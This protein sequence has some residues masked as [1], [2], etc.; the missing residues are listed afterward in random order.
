MEAVKEYR[1]FT[2]YQEKEPISRLDQFIS[3]STNYVNESDVLIHKSKDFDSYENIVTLGLD[4]QN[5]RHIFVIELDREGNQF[6]VSPENEVIMKTATLT[7]L[8]HGLKDIELYLSK[9]LSSLD[10]KNE[11]FF[12]K[13]IESNDNK[14]DG[15][16]STVCDIECDADD[17]G[18]ESP[19][20]Y[21]PLNHF[22]KKH[23]LSEE[24]K[25][26]K[27]YATAQK[28]YKKKG[29]KPQ[30]IAQCL[31]EPF[32]PENIIS[33]VM[34]EEKDLKK[35]GFL[36]VEPVDYN[37]FNIDIV[38]TEFS[39]QDLKSQIAGNG[40]DG[41]CMNIK[42]NK[43]L[44]PFF[45]PQISFKY[46]RLKGNLAN[47]IMNLSFFNI[48][49]WNPTNSLST[50]VLGVYKILNKHAVIEEDDQEKKFQEITT[51]MDI[52]VKN[53]H[54]KVDS[55]PYDI[56]DI[57][58]HRL[59]I[60]SS[61]KPG[62]Q[63]FW[64]KGVGYGHGDKKSDW[65][66]DDLIKVKQLKTRMNITGLRNL[67]DILS[68]F[69]VDDDIYE[70][71]NKTPILKII[72][73]FSKQVNI[74]EI[75]TNYGLYH[76]LV[77]IFK[78]LDFERFSNIDEVAAI[79]KSLQ[80]VASQLQIYNKLQKQSEYYQMFFK[81]IVLSRELKNYLSESGEN[82]NDGDESAYCNKIKKLQVSD[83]D[84]KENFHYADLASTSKPSNVCLKRLKK[85]IST[86]TN[87]LPISYDTSVVMRYDE[88]N[89]QCLK[90]MIFGG[91]DTPYDSGCFEFD[92][93]IPESY[94][95]KPPQVNF[96]TTGKCTARLNPNLYKKGKVCL[97]LLGTWDGNE[98][99]KW[100]LRE[101]TLLQLFVSLQSFIF[102]EKPYFNEPTYES[103]IGTPEGEKKSQEYNNHT[104][105]YTLVWG[106]YNQLVNPSTCFK[107]VIET[108]FRAKRNYII[109]TL[110][111][112]EAECLYIVH[113]S[114]NIKQEFTEYKEKFIKL[115]NRL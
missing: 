67:K 104:R 61:K 64:G 6:T 49:T 59:P 43:D 17:E 5:Y 23:E 93:F 14:S 113:E 45:P 94:P 22:N 62:Q 80:D 72:N 56:G 10:R 82:V 96:L 33:R 7:K 91:K 102:C 85:E 71:L 36:T 109:E 92:I 3:W 111:K 38:Y 70:Y 88:R 30:G 2:V 47:A 27:I 79:A 68:V 4:F 41:I 16:A 65:S 39:K 18:Y 52:L 63:N 1:N 112:W 98:S 103:K 32:T 86:Y 73:Y 114:I 97:T 9:F 76:E 26:K 105:F 13:K 95:A 55:C 81:L 84:S 69:I 74:V 89:I 77:E 75:Q 8:K 20:S 115:L 35:K 108:H 60:S 46:P 53:N 54:L 66:I 87:S 78:M 58:H 50:L 57:D 90:L 51:V 37:P 21:D 40:H 15:S 101:S 44:Y 107:E 99:E 42:I 25:E 24:S 11:N 34:K 29:F 31:E 28:L 106:M 12:K 83:F 110:D 100:D 48:D 19:N